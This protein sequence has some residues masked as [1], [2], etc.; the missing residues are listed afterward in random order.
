MT[1]FFS[2]LFGG[3]KEGGG[4]EAPA[5]VLS[6]LEHNGYRIS[7][8]P[9]REG[10]QFQTAGTISKE[11]PNGMKEHRFIRADRFASAEEAASFALSKGRQII[12]QLG[13]RIFES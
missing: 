3:G 2:R 10:G 1:G 4:A 7:A 6:T 8:A 11:F 9:F 5:P 12:D 13:D